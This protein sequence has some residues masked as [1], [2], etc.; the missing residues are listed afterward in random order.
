TTTTEP[1]TT[2][3][4]TRPPTTTTTTSTTTT[5]TEPPTTTTTTE[6][7]TTTSTTAPSQTSPPVSTGLL[8]GSYN[9]AADPSGMTSFASETDTT[10]SI[11]S[12]YL[13]GSSWSSMVGSAGSPP[14][15]ISQIK[16]KL[17]KSRLLLSVP[18][19]NAGYSTDQA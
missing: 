19:V 2:T 3:T 9:G 5:T 14:W 15:V 12:D 13:D 4:T 10:A 17:G 16:G 11:Y 7:P 6:P 8:L 18:L 1:P